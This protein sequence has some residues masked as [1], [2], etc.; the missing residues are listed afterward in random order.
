MG[1]GRMTR[2]DFLKA[3]VA[4]SAGLFAL[5][6][7]AQDDKSI[8]VRVRRPAAVSDG[9]Q[10][11]GSVVAEMVHTAVKRLAGTENL[12]EAWGKFVTPDDTVGIKINSLFGPGASTHLEV[13]QAIIQ[14]CTAAGVKPENIIV[15]DRRTAELARAGYPVNRDGP[16]PRW[17]GTDQAYEPNDTVS[18]QFRGRLSQILTRRIT[19][20][21]NA[22]VLKTHSITGLTFALKNHYGSFHNPQEYHGDHCNPYLADINAIS[23]I[24]EK[25]RLIIGDALLPIAAGGPRPRPQFTW[26]YAAILASTDPVAIDWVGLDILNKRRAKIGMD[27]ITQQAK[28]IFTAAQRGLGRV[29]PDGVTIVDA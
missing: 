11:D 29:G 15:W 2:R 23:H 16:G 13:V 14:G 6:A 19:A 10:V 26:P 17:Y 5:R 8:V 25:T 22:P 27:P 4:A 24:R 9:G 12:A 7:S 28:G 20:L 21:I 18:G 1:D 3:A